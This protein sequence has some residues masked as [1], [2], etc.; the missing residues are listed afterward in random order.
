[1]QLNINN[2]E[3]V[4]FTVKL[5]K[6][7]KSAL[8]SAI[9]GTLNDVAFNVKQDSMPKQ[10]KA[11]FIN[12][13]PNFFRATSRVE[14]ARG[15]DVNTM[16]SM[17]GFVE[18][19]LRGENNFSVKDLEQQE[20]SGNI[21]GRSFI[22]LDAARKGGSHSQLVTPAN[23]LTKINNVVVA[24]KMGRGTKKQKFV[25]SIY[26]AGPGGYVLGSS[27]K[28]EDILWRVNTIYPGESRRFLL[29]PLYD[30]RKSRSVKVDE[31]GF[32]RTA[33]VNSAKGMNKYYIAQAQFWI[34]RYA[35]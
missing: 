4:K 3:V 8:P 21:D 18:T 26:K 31:T 9:R 22:P 20:Y 32:M 23:R 15:F 30:F 10:A 19:G 24:S 5:E 35:K 25:S 28:G 17:V 11:D 13:S 1:M 2:N 16:R 14:M 33:S 34:N 7:R 27:T 29:T 12:R 6:L